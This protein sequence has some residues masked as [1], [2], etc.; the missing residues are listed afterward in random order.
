M[1]YRFLE[2]NIVAIAFGKAKIFIAQLLIV[3]GL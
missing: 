2:W 3:Y 1:E